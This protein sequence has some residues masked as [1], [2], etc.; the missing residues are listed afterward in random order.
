MRIGAHFFIRQETNSHECA[1]RIVRKRAMATT[2]EGEVAL[3]D[4]SH[5]AERLTVF[6]GPELSSMDAEHKADGSTRAGAAIAVRRRSSVVLVDAGQA[7]W[8]GACMDP[9]LE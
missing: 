7:H 6:L 2:L 4:V 1:E 8:T 3:P 5:K 9:H